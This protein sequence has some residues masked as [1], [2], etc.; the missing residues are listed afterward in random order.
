MGTASWVTDTLK[1]GDCHFKET[2]HKRA[3]TAQEMAEQEHVS[4]HHVAKTVAVR[5]GKNTLLLVLP[6]TRKVSLKRI[7]EI[8]GAES[9]RL[10]NEGEISLE[11]LDCELGAIPPFRHWPAVELWVDSTLMD[12]KELVFNGGTHTDAI[13]MPLDEWSAMTTPRRES[14]SMLSD[15]GE[16][17]NPEE[18]SWRDTA[19]R[20]QEMEKGE[21]D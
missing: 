20:I 12:E 19:N 3:L 9:V 16:I 4:G 5:A 7:K 1:V 10:L 8:T 2:H 11:F 14:F 18:E 15:L 6:A 13:R 21:G 17:Q